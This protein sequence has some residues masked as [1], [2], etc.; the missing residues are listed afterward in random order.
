VSV[1]APP[2]PPP[3]PPTLSTLVARE[4]LRPEPNRGASIASTPSSP[5]PPRP[6]P[7]PAPRRR[8]SLALSFL[9]GSCAPEPSSSRATR[10]EAALHWFPRFLS[11]SGVTYFYPPLQQDIPLDFKLPAKDYYN[12][13]R[14]ALRV[15]FDIVTFADSYILYIGILNCSPIT[16]AH[17]QIP[18]SYFIPSLSGTFSLSILFQAFTLK[19]VLVIN[20][21]QTLIS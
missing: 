3:P 17:L 12:D 1:E 20:A 15:T 18:L 6:P 5:P 7:N 13:E 11:G 21:L 16:S 8:P 14:Y 2:P 19:F 4:F 10:I 9:R